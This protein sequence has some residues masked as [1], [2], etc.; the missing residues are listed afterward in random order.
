MWYHLENQTI[1]IGFTDGQ[2]QNE[3]D[4]LI[5]IIEADK[6]TRPVLLRLQKQFQWVICAIGWL[7]IL[8]GS[9]FRYILYTYIFEQYKIKEFKP[10]DV[11]ILVATIIQHANI[12]S[13][14][15]YYTLVILSDTS[16]EY[17]GQWYCVPMKWFYLFDMFYSYIGSL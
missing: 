6:A 10:I 7:I 2:T 9:Y 17:I 1:A 3:H 11:L 14:V 16:L 8:S 4:F 5:H 15:L 13:W 12:V